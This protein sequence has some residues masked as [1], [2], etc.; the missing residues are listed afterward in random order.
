MGWWFVGA[1]MWVRLAN[2]PRHWRWSAKSLLFL[3]ATAA[4]MYPHPV[5]LTRQ[6]R[7]LTDTEA[8]IQ[9]H[10]PFIAEL[11]RQ[12]D[13]TLPAGAPPGQVFRAV[14]RFV[15]QAIPYAYD[16]EVW[17]N[18]DYWPTAAEVWEK[19]R[20]DCDGRAVLCASLLRARGFENVRLVGNI[21]H[22]WVEAD[23]KGLMGAEKDQN[24]RREGGRLVVT[25]PKAETL[26][27]GLSQVRHFPAWR[28][29]VLVLVA[30]ALAWH[31][32]QSRRGLALGAISGFA[33][34][35]A[36]YGWAAWSEHG[37]AGQGLL[38]LSAVLLLAGL[39]LAKFYSRLFARRREAQPPPSLFVAE[40]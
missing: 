34:L 13:T 32:R 20:E 24:F 2:L 26:L 28:L 30:V 39:A 14:E 10:L 25:P 3:L 9:P 19:R 33:G 31:P 17:S 12:I 7:H 8:L 4:V 37:Q 1:Q 18:V 21:N 38:V 35:A 5:Y 11:N 40:A 36:L 16:W 29:G 22:V 15:Y 6:L 23:G 27:K